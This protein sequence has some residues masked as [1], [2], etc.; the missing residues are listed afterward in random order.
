MD[1]LV[2][3]VPN[4]SEGRDRYI[5]NS[6]ARSIDSERNVKLLNISCSKDA[7]RTVIT[8]AGPPEEV[9]LA[10]FKGIK[11]AAEMIDMRKQKGRHPRFGATDLCP[12]IPL[13]GAG[14]D[15]TVKLARLLAGRVGD[16]LGIPVYCYE[17]AAFSE[18]RCSLANCRSGEYEGLRKK[19]SLKRW[20]PDFG[21]DRWSESIARTGAIAI[22]ARKLLVAYNINL[23]TASAEIAG[24]IAADIRES[25]RLIR[26]GIH[27][28]GRNMTGS[29]GKLPRLPGTL[30]KV[31][32]IGWY[33][34]DYQ[35]AQ[36]SMNLTDISITPVHRVFE[37][38]CQKARE[39]GVQVTGSELVGLVPLRAM[40]D[41]GKYFLEKQQRPAEVS[42]EEIIKVA[43]RSLG[44]DDLY[45]FN[46]G[47]RII[48]YLI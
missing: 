15:E 20:K 31:K 5:I 21:P 46:P 27:A 7:N 44:L 43:V 42:D 26:K 34:E 29:K 48:E 37:E 36:V 25:G 40:L 32:A 28:E 10:A 14:M 19:I 17:Y 33:L 16:E 38:V 24:K 35:V 11:K 2:E 3:C 8:F 39:Y 47:E 41:A 45:P 12:L 30:Q 18:E 13:R 9:V 23:N 4:F 1:R 22:G 6:I